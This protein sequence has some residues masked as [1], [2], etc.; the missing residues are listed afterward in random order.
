MQS[1]RNRSNVQQEAIIVLESTHVQKTLD[2]RVMRS[3]VLRIV[4]LI[5]FFKNY[6]N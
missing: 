1:R 4:L 6:F 5:K 2:E 3:F